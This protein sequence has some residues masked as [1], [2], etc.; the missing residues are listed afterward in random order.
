MK[1]ELATASGSHYGEDEYGFACYNIQPL[2][3]Q[4]TTT[5][6]IFLYQEH[7]IEANRANTFT[8]PSPPIDMYLLNLYISFK[9]ITFGCGVYASQMTSSNFD[10]VNVSYRDNCLENVLT[11][12]QCGHVYDQPK[13]S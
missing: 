3:L 7:V 6:I 9:W 13:G 2:I 11:S 12:Y 8:L 4:H 10:N 5:Y 1:Q